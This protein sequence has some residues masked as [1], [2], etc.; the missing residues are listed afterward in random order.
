[1]G[2]EKPAGV[3]KT[4]RT[5]GTRLRQER[6]RLGLTQSA[7][8][9]HI[10]TTQFNV[11][12][13]ENGVT[14]PGL[15]NRQRLGKLFGKSLQ[16][17]GLVKETEE[18]SA[19]H[20]M[21][22]LSPQ[23]SQNVPHRRNPFFTGREDILHHLSLALTA[24]KPTALPPAQ[25]ISG[26]GGIGKTQIAVEYVYRYRHLYDTVFWINASPH[27]ALVHDFVALAELLDLPEQKDQE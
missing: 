1:M 21:T 17:L 15:Y 27:N 10:G 9:E 24:H 20:E 19:E 18:E 16:E 13:W 2:T 12:R 25:A 8:A 3:K 26:L 23:T 22:D 14:T 11:S 7:L 6:E 5:V 4:S